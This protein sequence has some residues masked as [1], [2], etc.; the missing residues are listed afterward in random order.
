MKCQFSS[1][2]SAVTI[3]MHSEKSSGRW[4]VGGGGGGVAASCWGHSDEGL[5]LETSIFASL[6]VAHLPY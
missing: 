6:K 5:K 3:T 1:K 4:S 2:N